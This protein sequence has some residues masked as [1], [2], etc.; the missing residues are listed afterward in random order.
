MSFRKDL[1]EVLACP[2]CKGLLRV[3]PQEDGLICDRCRSLY[4]IKDDIPILLIDEAI[5][6]ES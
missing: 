6:L 4:P 5:R 1:L 2:E 3:T